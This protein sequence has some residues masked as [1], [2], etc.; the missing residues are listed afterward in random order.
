MLFRSKMPLVPAPF[1]LGFTDNFLA[2]G[3][4]F[5]ENIGQKLIERRFSVCQNPTG[6]LYN[7]LSML[8]TLTDILE[9]RTYQITDIFQAQALWH[10]WQHHGR[11]SDVSPALALARMNESGQNA[12]S[13]FEKT[14]RLL[15]TFGTA[16]VY[17]WVETGEIV[18]NCHKVP[19][20]QFVKRRLTVDEILDAYVPVLEKITSL[21]P[22]L[23]VVLTVSPVRHLRDG[24]I[25]NNRSKAVLLLAAEA[26]ANQFSAVYY[27]PAYEIFIDDLRDYRFVKPDLMHPTEQAIDYIWQQFSETFFSAKTQALVAE[28]EKLQHQEN[29]RPLHTNTESYEKF[30]ANLSEKRAEIDQKMKIYLNSEG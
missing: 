16:T 2:I 11:F 25:E 26:L 27:F 7:P 9:A 4:C 22:E 24:L 10:S 29:H 23:R 20:S 5:T 6:I 18:G 28:I 1:A 19:Q 17:E 8:R 3:S 30:K 15:L 14:N 13:F 21:K 12:Q